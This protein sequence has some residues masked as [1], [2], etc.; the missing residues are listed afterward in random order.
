MPYV[1]T[2]SI[3]I[4]YEEQGDG[5]PV[6]LIGGLTST[7]ETWGLQRSALAAR[8]R[9][10]LPDNRGSGRTRVP[11]DDGSRT[12]P[13]FAEDVRVLLDGLGLERVHLVGAS[14]G[15]LIVQAFALRH[16]ERLKSL[17][18]ACTTFGG[19]QAVAADPAVAAKLLDATGDSSDSS[20]PV[21]AHPDSQAK[22]PEAI[23]FYLDSK[24]AQPHSAAE[25]AAR[26]QAVAAFDAADRV[27]DIAVPTLVITGKQDILVPAENSRMLAERIPNAE[28]V[29]IDDAGHIF[30]CE[31]AEATNR[32]LLEFLARH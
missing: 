2:P 21:V 14:M 19:P 20:L 9:V 31:Q 4:Y 10:V 22:R 25:V 11:D 3:E 29:E 8:Y 5:E 26:A 24:K 32:A 7:V 18:L 23:R 17:V 28:L 6:V 1:T 15:G 13:E 27:C 12:I 30:F 16:P